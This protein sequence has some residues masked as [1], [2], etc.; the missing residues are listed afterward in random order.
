[1]DNLSLQRCS[2]T[3]PAGAIFDASKR[4]IVVDGARVTGKLVIAPEKPVFKVAGVEV[5]D[6]N[7]GNLTTIAGVEGK[8]SYDP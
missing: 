2:I 5:A 7:S 4:S 3:E 1:M 8:A 6:A